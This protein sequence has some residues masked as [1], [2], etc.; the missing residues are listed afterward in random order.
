MKTQITVVTTPEQEL[1]IGLTQTGQL[2]K[3]KQT[4]VKEYF[5]AE[6]D[7]VL[8][9]LSLRVRAL[10]QATESTERTEV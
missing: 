9:S 7:G 4:E 1:V 3:A 10:L 5:Q 2:K 6:V 8:G